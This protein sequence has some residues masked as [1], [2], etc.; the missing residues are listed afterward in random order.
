VTVQVWS[1]RG[2]GASPS[3]ARCRQP[4]SGAALGVAVAAE[5]LAVGSDVA[6]DVPLGIGDAVDVAQP[7]SST[8]PIAS[9]RRCRLITPR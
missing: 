2:D 4:T 3:A 5:V 9:G 1:A 8:I 7:P 6:L